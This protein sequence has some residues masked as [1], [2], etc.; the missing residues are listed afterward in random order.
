M[1][2]QSERAV[3]MV[4]KCCMFVCAVHGVS[5]S[6]TNI[7]QCLNLEL[8]EECLSEFPDVRLEHNRAVNGR[9]SIC[10]NLPI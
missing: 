8:P 5:A 4:K 3:V 9:R 1:D 6:V 7:V 10:Y 2:K